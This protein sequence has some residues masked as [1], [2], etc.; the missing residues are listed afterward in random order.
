MIIIIPSNNKKHPCHL[1][2][3][4]IIVRHPEKQKSPKSFMEVAWDE[5]LLKVR[6]VLPDSSHAE[7]IIDPNDI[8][9]ASKALEQ[10]LESYNM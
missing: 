7:I 10:R 2:L 6:V 4:E 9:R 8:I 5:S 3:E 1:E